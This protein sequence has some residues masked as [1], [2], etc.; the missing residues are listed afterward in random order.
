VAVNEPW[1]C[2]EDDDLLVVYKPAGVNTHRADTYAQQGMYEWVASQRAGSSL[3]IL[4]RLDKAT[5]GLLAFGKTPAANRALTDQ[6]SQGTIAKR[7][8]MIVPRDDSRADTMS[9]NDPIGQKTRDGSVDR[10]A[11]TDFARAQVGSTFERFDAFPHTGRTHQIRVHATNLAMEIVGDTA[12]GGLPAPRLFLHAAQLSFIGPTG[13]THKLAAPRPESFD[14]LVKGTP[15]GDVGLASL[16][17]HE[18]RS[19]LFDSQDTNAYVWIDRQHDGFDNVRVE[20]LD[21]A[22]LAINYS[23]SLTP[24]PTD[25]I[26]AWSE[27]F[28]GAAV[29]EQFR[30]RGGGGG[31]AQLVAG[32]HSSRFMVSELGAHYVIDLDASPTSTGLFLDQRE[33][34]RRIRSTTK[35]DATVLNTFG[36]TGSF[37]VAAAL[38]GAR[39]TTLDL[40]KRYLDWARENLRANGIS[41]DEHDF[42]FGDAAEWMDRLAKKGRTFDLV[43]LDPP[44]SSTAGKGSNRRWVVERD[45]HT[46]VE[47]GARLCTEGGTLFVSTNLRRMTWNQFLDHIDRGLAAVSR[48]GTI[49]TET[50]PIDHRSGP[51]DP[52]YLKAAWVRLDDEPT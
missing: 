35:R 49:E 1:V 18:A 19:A 5:S 40:S 13:T 46:L 52:P 48:T 20:R 41:V 37:S 47:R 22:L 10:P 21:D 29:F 26:N 31:Q 44:S 27:T 39:T 16:V 36:H 32:D 33:T 11:E 9:C 6:F 30:P 17:A 43:I 42:I 14:R 24:L 2:F 12:H 3:A 50:V 7:Y 28:G 38:A 51:G 45:L 34:R 23:D 4:H 15:N 25:W 8:E